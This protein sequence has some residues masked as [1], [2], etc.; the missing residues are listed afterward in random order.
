L[1]TNLDEEETCESFLFSKFFVLLD[2]HDTT[3]R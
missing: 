3:K 2:F 1:M